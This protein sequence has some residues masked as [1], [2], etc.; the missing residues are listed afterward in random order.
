MLSISTYIHIYRYTYIPITK[1]LPSY[2][3]AALEAL[4]FP[5]PSMNSSTPVMGPV[6]G[7][8]HEYP[9]G[10]LPI[11]PGSGASRADGGGGRVGPT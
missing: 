8:P 3:L 6:F 11:F 7:A 9:L 10:I 4:P 2:N 1:P 5:I